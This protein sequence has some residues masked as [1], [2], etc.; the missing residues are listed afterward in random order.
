VEGA[1][2]E[3]VSAGTATVVG[4]D[5]LR[6]LRHLDARAAADLA[7][8]LVALEVGGKADRTVNT[9]RLGIASLLRANMDKAVGDFT[10]SDIELWLLGVPRRSRHHARSIVSQFFGWLYRHERIA[11]NPMDKVERVQKPRRVPVHGF[12]EAERA[13][14]EALESPHGE[15]F[16]LLFGSGLRKGEA[17]GLRW[18]HVD[19][20]RDRLIVIAGKGDKDRIV[21]LLDTALTALSDLELFERPGPDDYVFCYTHGPR[22]KLKY[23][24]KH[25]R[26]EPLGHSSFARWYGDCLRAAGVSYRRPHTTR[27]TYAHVLRSL[28]YDLEER[29]LLL[30]HESSK[31]T[32]DIYGDDLTIEDVAQ[33]MRGR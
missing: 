9:Y 10:K 20:E 12:S 28:G 33:K 3:A 23:R 1:S 17:I 15:L 31:T 11:A 16:A 26:S 8:W 27:H 7:D 29:Q 30:G 25:R 24:A 6:D 18:Q 5:P 13:L 32:S 22:T 14:L 19:L 2:V 21:P 4:F